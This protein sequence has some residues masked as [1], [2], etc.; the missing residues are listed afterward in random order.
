[1]TR[2]VHAA[3]APGTRIGD[4]RI[5]GVLGMGGFGSTCRAYDENLELAVAITEYLPATL[6]VRDGDGSV[7]PRSEADHATYAWGLARFREEAQARAQVFHPNLVRVLRFFAAHDTGYMVIR[8]DEGES[9]RARLERRGPLDEPRSRPGS[10]RCWTGSARAHAA[11]ILHRDIRPEAIPVR[12]D[13]SP[14]L[15]DFR[16]ARRALDERTQ[17]MAG[18]PSLPYAPM[19]HFVAGLVARAVDGHLRA[20]RGGVRG[21]RRRDAARRARPR[22]RRCAGPARTADA[23]AM[24]PRARGGRHRGHRAHARRR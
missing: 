8:Y 9:L 11:G 5:D 14:V 13:G 10:I 1:M 20:R 18:T 24:P 12:P 6:A 22:H 7:R 23:R 4:Y 2:D 17:T 15:L 19:E 3:V 16:A 21:A